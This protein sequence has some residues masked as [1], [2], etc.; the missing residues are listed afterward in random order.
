[1]I[2]HP[3]HSNKTWATLNPALG[4]FFLSRGDYYKGCQKK[5]RHFGMTAS[6]PTPCKHILHSHSHKPSV[7]FFDSVQEKSDTLICTQPLRTSFAYW[8]RASTT[9]FESE[10]YLCKPGLTLSAFPEERLHMSQS[11][12]SEVFL[13]E[14]GWVRSVCQNN[15]HTLSNFFELYY[16]LFLYAHLIITHFCL[17]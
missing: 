11:I 8:H 17:A 13:W 3:Q 6:N 15:L 1:M 10:V 14:S 7:R 2:I 9:N 12:Y 16:L 5:T 4:A